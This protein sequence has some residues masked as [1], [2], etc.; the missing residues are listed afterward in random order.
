MNCFSFLNLPENHRSGNKIVQLV[1]HVDDVPAKKITFPAIAQVKEDG[2][3][4]MVILQSRANGGAISGAF[5]RTGKALT[6]LESIVMGFHERLQ[7]G[8][9]P[10][11]VYIGEVVNP[12]MSLEELSGVVNPNR[13]SPLGKELAG[14]HE[15]TRLC[16]HDYLTLNEFIDGVSLRPYLT[17]YM[18]LF[19]YGFKDK[20]ITVNHM[21]D[22]DA[23]ETFAAECIA[24]GHEGAV[25]KQNCDWLAGHKGYRA[26]KKVREVSYDLLC[27]GIEDGKGKREGIAAN[28]FFQWRDGQTLKA[29]LGKGWTDTKRA[30]LWD[31]REDSLLGPVGQIFR[32]YGLQD[33]SKGV[34]RLPKV[35]E[36]RHD[37]N[38]PDY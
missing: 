10:S 7:Q 30:V 8:S 11:G 25:L 21:W 19:D 5:G 15:H 28:L 13:K 38:T 32:V 1:K 24:E 14:L 3:Y 37:K 9:C 16:L 36:V 27:T 33:S 20:C 6:S 34:I 26:M 12:H 22:M 2:V 29:D 18:L 4:C 23:F 31:N 17:R 35:G